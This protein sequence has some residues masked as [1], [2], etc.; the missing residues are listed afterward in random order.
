[1]I[2]IINKI[3]RTKTK[4]NLKTHLTQTTGRYFTP[5]RLAYGDISQLKSIPQCAHKEIFNA[6]LFNGAMRILFLMLAVRPKTA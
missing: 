2:Q 4:N 3:S 6:G 5:Y 1:M